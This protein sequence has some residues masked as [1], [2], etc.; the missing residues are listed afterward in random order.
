MLSERLSHRYEAFLSKSILG[1][2]DPEKLSDYLNSFC[3]I[4]LGSGVVECIHCGFSVGAAFG[5]V[6]AD[7]RRVFLKINKNDDDST[8]WHIQPAASFPMIRQIKN[9]GV[10]SGRH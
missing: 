9:L 5:L 4:H 3:S 7:G 2:A 6:L 10:H 8:L 1:H